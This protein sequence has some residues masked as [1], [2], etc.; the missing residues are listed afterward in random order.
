[1]SSLTTGSRDEQERLT[2]AKEGLEEQVRT[3]ETQMRLAIVDHERLVGDLQKALSD[4]ERQVESA[5]EQKDGLEEEVRNL[6]EEMGR[7]KD[8]SRRTV[9]GLERKIVDFEREIK[10]LNAEN[11]RLTQ[12]V[13]S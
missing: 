3:L 8:E 11:D 9:N 7:I 12:Q 13:A 5:K 1:M 6:R 2:A 4:Y 10:T